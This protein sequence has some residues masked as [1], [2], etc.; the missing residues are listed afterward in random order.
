[1]TV[2]EEVGLSRLQAAEMRESK[3]KD[4]NIMQERNLEKLLYG[5][6]HSNEHYSYL[7]MVLEN[8]KME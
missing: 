5:R 1:M 8:T 3:N 2:D 6:Y 7:V 4:W